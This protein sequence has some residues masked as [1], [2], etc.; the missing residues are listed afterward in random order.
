MKKMIHAHWIVLAAVLLCTMS[1]AAD[2]DEI[3][4]RQVPDM[5]FGVNI[6]SIEPSPLVADDWQCTDPRPVTDVHFWGSYIGWQENL[7]QPDPPTPGVLGFII[8]FYKDVPAGVD[9][10][11]SHPGDLLYAIRVDNFQ[12]LYT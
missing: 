7:P 10:P 4:W 2:G 9:R 8:R 3:K 5:A 1:W 12:E 6:E 11:Y